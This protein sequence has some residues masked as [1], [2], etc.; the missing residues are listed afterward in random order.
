MARASLFI[1]SFDFLEVSRFHAVGKHGFFYKFP[2]FSTI[3]K[4]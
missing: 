1:Y 2:L 3:V 4:E